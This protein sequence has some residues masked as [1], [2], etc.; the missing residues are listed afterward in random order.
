MLP[1]HRTAGIGS[2]SCQPLSEDAVTVDTIAGIEQW[3]IR[4]QLADQGAT[5]GSEGVAGP[6][7]AGGQCG[8][9][10]VRGARDDLAGIGQAGKGRADRIGAPHDGAGRDDIRQDAIG[11]SKFFHP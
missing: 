5:Q 11:Q 2:T 9:G 10:A 1:Q 6:F 8:G 7:Q 3:C 4:E